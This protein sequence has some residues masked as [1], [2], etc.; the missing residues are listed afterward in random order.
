MDNATVLEASG[1]PFNGP[2]IRVLTTDSVND[3][4]QTLVKNDILSA[5]VYN[6]ESKTYVG[7]FDISD[8]LQLIY[9]SDF[10][11][12]LV[13]EMAP[14][15]VLRGSA[16]EILSTQEQLFIGQIFEDPNDTTL[17]R[18]KWAPVK[19]HDTLHHVLELLADGCR[20]VPVMN[21][22]GEILKIVSQS[23][24]VAALENLLEAQE[25]SKVPVNEIFNKSLHDLNLG[26]KPVKCLR[27]DSNTVKDAFGLMTENGISA[28]G[29]T[30]D[31]GSLFTCITSKD[32][33]A[34]RDVKSA[35]I[36]RFQSE[37]ITSGSLK[38]LME[39][40]LRD[41]T[42]FT[43][44]SLHEINISAISVVVRE[45]TTLRTVIAKLAKTKKHRVF[46][47][48]ERSHPIGV[49]SVSDVAQFLISHKLI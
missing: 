7:F 27:A 13:C 34:F 37:G 32:I 36:Q 10:F 42:A 30:D 35:M 16:S 2:V 28:V 19:E 4:F 15:D 43:R 26:L 44:Q 21:D 6:P 24:V 38:V 11:F 3:G 18:P 46:I 40:N 22:Q 49:V 14:K 41:F 9:L 29:I 45:T 31:D 47:V 25:K 23:A 20:R 8:A 17:N 1:F 12:H 33:R 5:P 39:M 48:D